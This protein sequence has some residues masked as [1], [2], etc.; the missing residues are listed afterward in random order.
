MHIVW[1]MSTKTMMYRIDVYSKNPKLGKNNYKLT[2][3]H[4]YDTVEQANAAK[5]AL[6]KMPRKQYTYQPGENRKE[7]KAFLGGYHVSGP[8]EDAKF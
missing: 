7:I 3:R 5:Y 4:W 8:F 2:G 6:T 1:I